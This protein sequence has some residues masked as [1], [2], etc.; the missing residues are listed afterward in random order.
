MKYPLEKLWEAVVQCNKT[1]DGIFYY[2][3]KTTGIFCRPSCKSKTPR[4][5]NVEFFFQIKDAVRSEYRPCKRCRPDRYQPTYHPNEKIARDIKRI[6]ENEYDQSWTLHKLS[7]RVGI[8]AYHLQRLFKNRTGRS[9]RQY[10]NQVRIRQAK[11]LLL[12]GK[13]NNLEICFAVGFHDPNQ[14]YTA[15]RKE[16]GASPLAFK[17]TAKELAK[18]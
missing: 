5:E 17:R 7:K 3:V 13:Q 14:F 4:K 11:Q 1:Y 16:T 18:R 10:L 2:A 9:P 12:E 15:F 6:L 8:S